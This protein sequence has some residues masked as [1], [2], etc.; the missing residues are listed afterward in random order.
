MPTG[1]APT[2]TSCFRAPVGPTTVPSS[3]VDDAHRAGLEVHLWTLRLENQFMATNFRIGTDPNAP[4]DLV[5]ETRAFL[6]AGVDGIFSD[7]PDVVAAA[8]ADWLAAG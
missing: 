7:H 1:W 2:R 6:D 3:L 8:T 4:G 5:A